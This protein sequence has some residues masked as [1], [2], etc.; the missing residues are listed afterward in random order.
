MLIEFVT[1]LFVLIGVLLVLI[2][3]IQKTSNSLGIGNMGGRNVMLFGS[4]GGQDIFQKI[5]WVLGI[6]FMG[7]SLVLSILKTQQ[8]RNSRYLSSQKT[9]QVEQPAE[10]KK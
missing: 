2:V 7:G 10:Q 3:L 1:A 9:I 5:T 6:L 4:S 8:V